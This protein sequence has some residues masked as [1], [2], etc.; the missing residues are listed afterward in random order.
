VVAVAGLHRQR[1]LLMVKEVSMKHDGCKNS[2]VT[3]H[4]LE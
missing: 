1:R 3:L 2:K 4:R